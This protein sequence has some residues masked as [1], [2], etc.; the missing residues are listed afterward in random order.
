LTG[1]SVGTTS[2]PADWTVAQVT[3]SSFWGIARGTDGIWIVAQ[4]QQRLLRVPLVIRHVLR[5]PLLF[6]P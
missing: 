3:D 6:R 2:G 4:G 5:I 1:A